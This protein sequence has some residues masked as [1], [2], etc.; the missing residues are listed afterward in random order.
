MSTPAQKIVEEEIFLKERMKSG[1]MGIVQN[2]VNDFMNQTG[3][4][5]QSIEIRF[6]DVSTLD[7][8]TA[9]FHYMNVNYIIPK[10]DV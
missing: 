9:I 4:K 8:P 2:Q 10:I 7:E 6:L 3:T 1:V 5:V